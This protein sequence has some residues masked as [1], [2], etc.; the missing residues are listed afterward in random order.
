MKKLLSKIAD[1]VENTTKTYVMWRH[2]FL[3]SK[4]IS[5]PIRCNRVFRIGGDDTIYYDH[6]D[7]TTTPQ[8]DIIGEVKHK[9]T[10]GPLTYTIYLFD[11]KSADDIETIEEFP[12]GHKIE[13]AVIGVRQ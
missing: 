12:K 7:W 4:G 1:E 13:R 2:S 10:H 5:Y 6:S 9:V 3:E 8:G 11:G